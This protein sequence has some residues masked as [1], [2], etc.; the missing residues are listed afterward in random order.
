ML[1]IVLCAIH[2][3]RR[4]YSIFSWNSMVIHLNKCVGGEVLHLRAKTAMANEFL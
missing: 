1:L 4:K 3:A 2:S